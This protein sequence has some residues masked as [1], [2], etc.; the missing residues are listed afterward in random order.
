[1]VI[2]GEPLGRQGEYGRLLYL[3]LGFAVNLTLLTNM[4]SSLRVE[5]C[6]GAEMVLTG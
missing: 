2:I 3:P 1:M 6:A 4:V 5:V